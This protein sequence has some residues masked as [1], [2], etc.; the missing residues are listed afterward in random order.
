MWK[1]AAMEHS[2]VLFQLLPGWT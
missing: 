2:E 1:E